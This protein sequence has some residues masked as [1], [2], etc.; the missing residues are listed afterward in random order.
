MSETQATKL[1]RWKKVLFSGIILLGC[2]ALLELAAGVALRYTQGYDGEHLLQYVFDPYKNMLP[3]PGY[4]DVRGVAYNSQGFREDREIPRNKPDGTYRIF[5]MG[6]STAHGTGG[7]WPHLQNEY[8]VLTNEETIDAY[9][10]QRLR[11][12]LPE[13]QIEVVNAA[14]ASTWMHHHLI[15]VNQTILNFDPD[16]ILFLDG[17]NDH[18]QFEPGHDQFESYRYKDHSNVILGP[19]T[20]EALA[21]ANGWWFFRKSALAHAV[22]RAGRNV[23]RIITPQPEQVPIDVDA[24][25]ASVE[26][27]FQNNALEM[28][29]RIALTLTHEEVVPVFML[30]PMLILERERDA[31]PIERTLFEFNVE[32]YLPGYE[33]FMTRAVPVIAGLEKDAVEGLGGHFLDLTGI[34][35][36]AEG[37]IFTD[38][39]HLTPRGNHLLADHVAEQILPL[40]QGQP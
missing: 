34:Y 23:K 35:D 3:T 1:P 39:A 22:M 36:G 12:L 27:T 33:E 18:F 16:M 5:L 30:Q 4:R 15:Y 29:E 8:P 32:S 11:E 24:A 13:R 2:L 6:A 31:P 28:I 20:V 26:E 9:L 37:Q 14:I 25:V 38:Y 7:L 10:E 17:F 19:P 21:A 40:I